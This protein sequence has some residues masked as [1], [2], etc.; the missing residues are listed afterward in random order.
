MVARE[1]PHRADAE[2]IFAGGGRLT[3]EARTA[4][5]RQSVGVHCE[6]DH[7]QDVNLVARA[8]VQGVEQVDK[9]QAVDD[10]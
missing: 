8:L 6:V 4:G 5:G 1:K 10:I 3:D 7:E 9:A 2:P